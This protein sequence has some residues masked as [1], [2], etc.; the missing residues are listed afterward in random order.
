M[1]SM[2]TER[3]RRV[4]PPRRQAGAA[5]STRHTDPRRHHSSAET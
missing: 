4:T 5:P 3:C 1:R 2:R